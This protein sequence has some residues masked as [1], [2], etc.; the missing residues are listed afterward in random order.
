[1]KVVEQ[2]KMKLS[3]SRARGKENSVYSGRIMR[4]RDLY[5]LH[6]LGF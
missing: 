4:S 1:M 6:I 5:S 2:G 3:D